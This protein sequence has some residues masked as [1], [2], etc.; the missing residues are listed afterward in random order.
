MP[1]LVQLAHGYPPHEVAGTEIYTQ[2]VSEGLRRRGWE[3]HVIAST[4]SP[5]RP[6]GTLVEEEGVSR[7]VNNLPW[8]PLSA[9]EKDP[10]IEGRVRKAL[11]TLRPDIVHVQHLLFLSAHIPM[12]APSL[13]TLHDAWA[14]CPRANLL[15]DGER[16]CAGPDP[17]ACPPCYAPLVSSSMADARLA[18]AA[19][20]VSRVVS[21]RTLHAAWRRV[22]APL[23]ALRPTSPVPVGALEP[24]QRAVAKA[25]KRLDRLVAPSRY[26]AERARA[27]GLGEV[28]VLPHGVEPGV[29]RRGGG[30]PIF[31]GSLVPHKGAHLVNAAVPEAR[32]YGPEVDAEYASTLKN[33]EGPVPNHQVPELLA[34]AEALVMGSVWPENAPLVVLEARASGCP[35]VAPRIGGLPELIEEGVDGE[36]YEPGSVESLRAALARLRVGAPSPRPAPTFEEHLDALVAHY[37]A[38]R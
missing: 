17:A 14:F 31:L 20:R 34:G 26:L 25:F 11:H 13:G 6:H 7:V 29:P 4:R 33:V 15:K 8:R 28:H 1:R 30:P 3:V 24:R 21:P 36:L 9:C 23:K 16:P 22:P 10:L 18:E 12:P 5:G 38:L 2:R 37:D 19:G 32:I 35:V 27:E